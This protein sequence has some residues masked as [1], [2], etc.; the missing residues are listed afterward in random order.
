MA[1]FD[2]HNMIMADTSVYF[3]VVDAP[4]TSTLSSHRGKFGFPAFPRVKN[5]CIAQ[6]V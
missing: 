1:L 3:Y 5:I 4:K 6:T 2:I